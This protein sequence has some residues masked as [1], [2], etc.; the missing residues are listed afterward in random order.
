P[1]GLL[2][3]LGALGVPITA[4]R[5]VAID[6]KYI[7]LGAPIFLSTTAPNSSKPLKRLMIA[8]DSG[9]AIK[10][11]VRADFF[12]GAGDAAGVKAGAMKQQGEIWVLLPK[13]FVLPE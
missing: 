13:D 2:G 5:S 9:G 6:P 10:G 11:G 12:W 3:P 4:E 1:A 7:P 8:Q